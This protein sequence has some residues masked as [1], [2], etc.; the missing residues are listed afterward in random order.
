MSAS[1]MVCNEPLVRKQW[2]RVKE[3]LSNVRWNYGPPS[4]VE[5][6]DP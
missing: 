1:M 5:E 4:Q 6:I 3:I 2:E